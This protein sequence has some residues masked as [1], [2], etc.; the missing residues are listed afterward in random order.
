MVVVLSSSLSGLFRVSLS[1]AFTRE[2]RILG[3][4]QRMDPS[5][6]SLADPASN[7][8]AGEQEPRE[9]HRQQP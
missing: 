6:R 4:I 5:N 9:P 3:E 7:A 1:A 2:H 8:N